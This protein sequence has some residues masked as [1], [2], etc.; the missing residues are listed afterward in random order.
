MAVIH[1]I[2]EGVLDEAVANRL[3]VATD[4]TPGHCYPKKGFTYIKNKIKDFNKTAITIS[5][6]ALVDFMDTGLPCPGAVVTTWLPH[7]QPKMLFRVAVREIESWLLADRENIASFLKVAPTKIPD[8]PEELNDPKL[9]LINLARTS[10]SK[11]IRSALVPDEGSTAS[12]GR[13]Y[14][15][16]LVQFV[17]RQWNPTNAC[18][19]APSLERCCKRLKALD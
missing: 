6:L 7:R 11:T 2:V 10:R 17:Y 14:T 5:Y 8:K 12:E 4:H 15:P 9:T 1:M 16:E 18:R 19:N 13:L 3:I